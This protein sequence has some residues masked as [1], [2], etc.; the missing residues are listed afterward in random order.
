MFYGLNDNK[1]DVE[2]NERKKY[3]PWNSLEKFGGY[4]T[5]EKDNSFYKIERFF[6]N[7]EAEDTC[8]LTHLDTGKIYENAFDLGKRLFEIDEEGFIYPKIDSSLCINCELCDKICPINNSKSDTKYL[9]IYA[10]YSLDENVRL[11]S[12]SGGIFYSLATNIIKNNGYVCGVI[13]DDNIIAKHTIIDNLEDLKKTQGSKYVQSNKGLIY[14]QIKKILD[15]NKT[16][17]FSGTPCEVAALKTYLR[18]DYNNLY[19]IDILCHGV[20]SPIIFENYKNFL[21]NKYGSSIIDYNFRDK[22]TG[23]SNYSITVNF[24]NSK[25]YTM[26][27]KKDPYMNIFLRNANIRPS[28]FN[29]KF[30]NVNRVSDITLGDAWGIQNI[31]PEI[32]FEKGISLIIIQNGRGQDLY[33]SIMPL[34]FSKNIETNA[35]LKLNNNAFQ[36]VL[37]HKD[38]DKVF[39]DIHNQNFLELQQE[40][41]S[42]NPTLINRIIRKIKNI[43]SINE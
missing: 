5:F 7:K 15:D 2:N 3:K 6:G 32:K 39:Q 16:L 20:P 41:H 30:K 29:C 18:K 37:P 8:V 22:S 33:D 43:L 26:L 12:S 4:I 27:Q 11:N 31:I 10:A 21:I 35:I 17:L 42:I 14:K 19:T 34:I 38:R 36:S 40:I 13:F 28:C 23:W 1:R 24:A 25:K 9:S